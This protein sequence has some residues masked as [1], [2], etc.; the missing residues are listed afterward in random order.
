MC[1]SRS[2]LALIAALVCLTAAVQST[3]LAQGDRRKTGAAPVFKGGGGDRSTPGRKPPP[4]PVS[5]SLGTLKN[6]IGGEPGA[7]F[8]KLTP[9]DPSVVNRGALVFVSPTLVEGGENYATWGP[10]SAN[11]SLFGSEGYLGLW[12]RPAAGKKY[13]I[14]CSVQ[15]GSEGALFSIT[16]PSGT[17]PTQVAG[18]AG[19]QHLAFVLDATDNKWQGFQIRGVGSKNK[20]GVGSKMEW[21]FY[22]CEV[23]NL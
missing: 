2:L 17:A 19:G 9:K 23:T 15:S 7:I 5:L 18:V 11:V 14:D 20:Y 1:Q 10:S 13:L 4:A 21:T 6:L 16:G 22:S 3:L 8:V 12:L